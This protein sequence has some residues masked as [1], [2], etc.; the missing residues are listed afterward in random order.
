[1]GALPPH[2][3]GA[4]RSPVPARRAPINHL[5]DT[6]Q[7][8]YGPC[9]DPSAAH[10]HSSPWCAAQCS[11]E[12]SNNPVSAFILAITVALLQ[13]TNPLFEPTLSGTHLPERPCNGQHN[14]GWPLR[15][16]CE[17]ASTII[18]H[19]GEKVQ[20]LRSQAHCCPRQARYVGPIGAMRCQPVRVA[21]RPHRA[22]P[23]VASAI[24][25]SPAP[26]EATVTP[27]VQG[28]CQLTKHCSRSTRSCRRLRRGQG[29]A[30]RE[31]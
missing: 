26:N 16:V 8:A 21:Q 15:H 18:M 4:H 1:M 17:S 11:P 30:D 28:M 19:R 6:T 13:P 31:R 25:E 2:T 10:G 3:V 5:T 20:E 24:E 22:S 14:T 29:S 7:D 27:G 12:H 23:G 9:G